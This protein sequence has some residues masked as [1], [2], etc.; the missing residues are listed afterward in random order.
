MAAA[1][2]NQFLG[3]SLP[4][5]PVSRVLLWAEVLDVATTVLGLLAFP[6]M[7]E[8]NPLLTAMG[9]WYSLLL[10]KLVAVALVIWVLERVKSWPPLVWAIPI[11]AA[12]P[13]VWNTLCLLAEWVI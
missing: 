12:I 10:V 6:Q 8:A 11:T 13:V 7:W 2:S 3:I 5:K 1:K 4:L 9:S